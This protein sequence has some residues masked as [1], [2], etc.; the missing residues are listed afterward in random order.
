M[1]EK[2][3]KK[4]KKTDRKNKNPLPLRKDKIDIKTKQTEQ[5]Y[6]RKCRERQNKMNRKTRTERTD[7]HKENGSKID[8][9]LTERNRRKRV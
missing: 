6:K 8:A 2:T 3:R 9:S 4:G 5:K 7:R 1:D